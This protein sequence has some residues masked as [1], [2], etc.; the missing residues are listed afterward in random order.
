MYQ[1]ATDLHI[2]YVNELKKEKE[3]HLGDIRNAKPVKWSSMRIG[4]S[5]PTELS[6]REFNN[7]SARLAAELTDSNNMSSS[8]LMSTE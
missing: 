7:S 3:K 5:A 1:Q 6:L 8:N 2:F 4:P